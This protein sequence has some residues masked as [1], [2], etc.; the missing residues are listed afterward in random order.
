MNTL[1]SEIELLKMQSSLLNFK[2]NTSFSISNEKLLRKLIFQ[3]S[4]HS[5]QEIDSL[6]SKQSKSLDNAR[7]IGNSLFKNN[8]SN[9]N[10]VVSIASQVNS[11]D[12]NKT[13]SLK[14]NK[15][16]T[17]ENLKLFNDLVL[18]SD[19][20]VDNNNNILTPITN[21]NSNK[22]ETF[23]EKES[24]NDT[25][26]DIEI[27]NKN[28]TEKLEVKYIPRLNFVWTLE[29]D[30]AI[31]L[32]YL[33][34]K[35]KYSVLFHFIKNR[36]VFQIRNRFYRVVRKYT[37]KMK[38][39]LQFINL[40]LHDKIIEIYKVLMSE[41]M[42]LKK[43]DNEKQLIKYEETIIGVKRSTYDWVVKELDLIKNSL[44]KKR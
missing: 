21:L 12:F 24:S 8:T 18:A 15:I 42:V 31:F 19:N 43:F 39:N 35:A 1:G 28:S 23:S 38:K 17:N 27:L 32:V 20:E 7:K 10:N 26:S 30:Y 11:S 13:R 16:L 6:F 41:I 22:T 5:S 9:E 34:C 44:N 14:N 37:K 25:N 2:L 40:C 29:Q 36:T 33:Y 3:F 4:F